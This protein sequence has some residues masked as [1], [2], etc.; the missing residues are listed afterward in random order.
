M[1]TREGKKTTMPLTTVVPSKPRPKTNV[2]TGVIATSGTERITMAIGRNA[3]S[4]VWDRTN[5]TATAK[6]TSSP[7]ANPTPASTPVC[8]R[9]VPMCDQCAP[10][11]EPVTR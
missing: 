1:M 7:T 3:A 8:C 11:S 5:S 6:A 4:I 2:M 9:P 10:T